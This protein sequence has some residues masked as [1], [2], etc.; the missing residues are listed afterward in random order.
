MNVLF[1]KH[2]LKQKK[3]ILF[4][5]IFSVIAVS[6]SIIKK[7]E[8]RT[9]K[10]TEIYRLTEVIEMNKESLD[11]DDEEYIKNG[12]SK[13]EIEDAKKIFQE[14]IVYREKLL[15]AINN[16]WKILYEDKLEMFEQ[17]ET[18]GFDEYNISDKSKE[19]TT[20]FLHYLK[21]NN[22]P[23]AYPLGFQYTKYEDPQSPTE[24]NIIER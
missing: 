12:Y 16:N 23:S 18:I 13:E 24:R 19:I 3:F 21:D 5:I 22:I 11:A 14:G 20:K 17:S 7:S 9:K 2:F 15:D 6:I 1:V 10:E 8:Y 4:F